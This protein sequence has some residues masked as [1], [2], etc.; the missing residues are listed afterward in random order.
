MKVKLITN[1]RKFYFSY[2]LTNNFIGNI[3]FCLKLIRF[4]LRG[5]WAL[6]DGYFDGR[7]T[8]YLNLPAFIDINK[9]FK[10]FYFSRVVTHETIH[11]I[12]KKYN[13]NKNIELILKRLLK[14]E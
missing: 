12:L 2:I 6:C 7:N 5:Y 10:T 4:R 11:K 14:N 3:K 8:I 13:S 9:R 1:N